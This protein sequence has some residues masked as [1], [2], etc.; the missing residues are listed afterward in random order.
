MR[1]LILFLAIFS[2]AWQKCPA[3][4]PSKAAK[5]LQKAGD[6]I[7]RLKYTFDQ[8]LYANRGLPQL[9]RAVGA[10]GS[11]NEKPEH[12]QQEKQAA[13]T[14][15]RG[16]VATLY[17][18]LKAQK[19]IDDIGTQERWLNR[20]EEALKAQEGFLGTSFEVK[21]NNIF[22]GET[23]QS[24]IDGYKNEIAETKKY[25]EHRYR[26][27]LGDEAY[28]QLS[29]DPNAN[30]P[31]EAYIAAMHKANREILG[32]LDSSAPYSPPDPGAAHPANT[33]AAEISSKAQNK[34][35]DADL[36]TAIRKDLSKVHAVEAAVK[37][38]QNSKDQP[39]SNMTIKAMEAAIREPGRFVQPPGEKYRVEV[40]EDELKFE[41]KSVKT[42][43]AHKPP[44]PAKEIPGAV[45]GLTHN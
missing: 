1:K 16:V 12:N 28:E 36:N 43:P 18:P 27:I 2:L 14:A 20:N 26:A 3:P 6:L 38:F 15:G 37:A 17:A 10:W 8:G 35:N 23:T 25:L 21:N 44:Q 30:L 5:K 34:I 42:R 22:T 7:G 31:G 9:K 4:T 11:F 45:A 29:K 19:D 13:K 32:N 33:L 41:N 24:R 39:L 40:E